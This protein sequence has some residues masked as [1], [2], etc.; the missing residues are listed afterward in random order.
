MQ[1]GKLYSLRIASPKFADL[2]LESGQ[3]LS[4]WK[5]LRRAS[6]R[7]GFVDGMLIADGEA[8]NGVGWRIYCTGWRCTAH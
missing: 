5:I 8:I 3:T 6:S 4:F 7:N 2:R 1:R